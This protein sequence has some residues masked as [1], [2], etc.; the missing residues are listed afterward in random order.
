MSNATNATVDENTIFAIGSNTKIFTAIILADMVE[1]GL[2]KLD[3]PIEKHLI[4]NVTVL[5]ITLILACIFT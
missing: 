5:H 4:P 3:V 1:Y 2:I